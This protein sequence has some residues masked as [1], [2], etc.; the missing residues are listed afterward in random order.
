V[1]PTEVSS[2]G[3]ELR[4]ALLTSVWLPVKVMAVSAAP[5][6]AKDSPAVAQR[7]IADQRVQRHVPVQC[8]P[9]RRS[10]P[11]PQTLGL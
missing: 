9:R 8:P 5:S 1:S 7:Q 2:N 11:R 3:W 4:V 6:A 10:R